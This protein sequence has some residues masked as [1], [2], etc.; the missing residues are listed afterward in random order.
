MQ[1]VSLTMSKK[2]SCLNLFSL[3]CHLLHKST[4]PLVSVHSHPTISAVEVI[5]LNAVN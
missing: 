3:G 2:K 4:S 5:S 1:G